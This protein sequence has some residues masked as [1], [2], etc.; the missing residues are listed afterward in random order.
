MKQKPKE[1]IT[2]RNLDYELYLDALDAAKRAGVSV[3]LWIN[4]AIIAKLNKKGVKYLHLHSEG[5]LMPEQ[6]KEDIPCY[7][8][9]HKGKSCIYDQNKTCQEGLCDECEKKK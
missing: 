9:N 6:E 3:G 2:I 5:G 8:K 1:R 4:E 7:P